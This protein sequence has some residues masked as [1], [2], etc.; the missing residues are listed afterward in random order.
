M[1]FSWPNSDQI[2]AGLHHVYTAVAAGAAVLVYVGLSQG[3]ATA[4][5]KGVQQ[6]GDGLA[7]VVA[8]I[9]TLIP[10]ASAL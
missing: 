2:N 8:G 9:T 7:S 6:I 10:V 5:G 3:D 4:L 1:T